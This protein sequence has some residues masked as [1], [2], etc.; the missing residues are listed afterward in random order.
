MKEPMFPR[1]E[2]PKLNQE[3]R[4]FDK[5][6]KYITPDEAREAKKD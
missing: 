2:K 1:V 4:G 6:G 3:E 5:T